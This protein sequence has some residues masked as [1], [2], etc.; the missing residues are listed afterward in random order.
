VVWTYVAAAI[1]GGDADPFAALLLSATFAF[2][3]GRIASFLHQSVVP[4]VAIAV[5][6]VLAMRAP[7]LLSAV[8]LSGPFRYTNATGA[9][10]LQAAIA[11]LMLAVASGATPVR[12]IGV[13]AAIAFGVV[14]FAVESLTPAALVLLLPIA[15]LAARIFGRTRAVVAGCAVLFVVALV[16]TIVVGSAY[17]AE[18]RS[19]FLDRLVDSTL[20]E[21]RAVLWHEA[22]VMMVENP[23]QGVGVGG[24]QLLS[25]TARLDRD[26]RWA[27]NGFLQQ[28]A[29]TGVIGLILL[30]LLFGWGFA[31]LG[32]ITELD[33]VGVLGAV[34]V[35]ALGIHASVDYI[36]HF[37]A[38]P[39]TAAALV[40]AAS[41]TSR[42]QSSALSNK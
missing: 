21:R 2:V 16:A 42:R 25:P 20:T 31:S 9:Y 11:G 6:V 26:A 32:A 19:A 37:P 17:S 10:Y 38:V 30:V 27:H 41:A 1:S 3:L 40:G 4:A 22:V 33:T 29:E 36:L 24:F 39:I 18:N 12:F 13:G 5:A 8:P 15:V 28:G 34:A 35:A 7:D 14:P 23:V